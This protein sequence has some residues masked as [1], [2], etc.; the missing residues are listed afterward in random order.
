MRN[1][2]LASFEQGSHQSVIVQPNE[3]KSVVGRDQE[4]QISCLVPSGLPSPKVYWRNSEGHIVSDSGPVRVQDNTLVIA[5]A[6]INEDEGN[7]TCVAENLA[8]ETD[9]TVEV[10]VT[11]KYTSSCYIFR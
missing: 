11:G 2:S 6:R 10:M 3:L 4:L 7:Y 1:L 8:G 5:K 9:M